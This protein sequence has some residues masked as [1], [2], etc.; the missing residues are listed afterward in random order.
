MKKSELTEVSYLVAKEELKSTLISMIIGFII[1][2][3]L[4]WMT[5][6][7]SDNTKYRIMMTVLVGL[8]L[9][10]TPYVWRHFP[11]IALG[12]MSLLI[13]LIASV[14]L[15]WV[16]TPVTLIYRLIEVKVYEGKL[17]RQ[18]RMEDEK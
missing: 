12:W 17:K 8:V 15:G 4:A 7:D 2:A 9:S 11:Y 13:K 5:T 6:M 14:C 18:Q 1:G 10:G 16:I 3:V